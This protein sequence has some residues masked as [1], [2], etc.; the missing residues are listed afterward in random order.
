MYARG[1]I[2]G[3][4]HATRREHIIWTAEESIAYQSADLVTAMEKDMG[5]LIAQL[6]VD[7]GDSRD[8]FLMYFQSDILAKT[9]HCL[10]IRETTALGEAYLAGLAV[11]VWKSKVELQSLWRCNTIF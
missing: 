9:V 2:V 1:M 10:M 5:I 3:L 11:G 8:Q 4:T 6:K 7:G